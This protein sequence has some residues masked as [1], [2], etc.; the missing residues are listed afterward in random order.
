M[1]GKER[2][3]A[4][5]NH[6]ETA[7][8]PIDFGATPVSGIHV[9][10][11]EKLRAH[12][13]LP[14][15][16]IKLIEPYQMLGEIEPDLMEIIGI[17]AIGLS[18]L[19]NMFGM[20][21]Q[22]WKEFKTHWGQTVLVPESF[23]VSYD[24]EGAT[25]VFP[26]G[27]TSAEPS[28][29]MPKD[30]FFFDA[31]V[32]QK[33]I[34]EE[35]LKVED[36]LE[37]FG[38]LS[39]DDLLYWKQQ[40]ASVKDSDKAVVANFGGTGLGDI[41][42]VPAMNLRDP[43]GIR[44]VAEWYMSTVMRMDYVHEI[45][46]KQTDIALKNLARLKPIAGDTVDAVFICGTDFG[47]QDS[48]FCSPETYDE[49]YM[50]YYKK[51]NDW[52]HK[53]TNWKTFKHCCGAIESF[54]EQFIASGFDIMNPVQINATGMDPVLLKDKYGDRIT[55]WG[56]GVDTQK[57]LPYGTP[58]EVK[59]QVKTQCEILG[60]KGGFVFNAVHNIQ[61]NTP[62]ENVVAMIDTLNEINRK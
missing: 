50:P 40:I 6:T 32:R 26:A 39:D 46:E 54:M 27:D 3:K 35:Q 48:T 22:G 34:D 30:S 23:H 1:T 25:Y 44:D 19:C 29:K 56:G 12:F 45:F 4:A 37:E 5:L 21:Q 60:R 41:A 61:A 9:R 33:P 43:K 20:P 8:V 58:D 2:I 57:V 11:V 14:Q 10:I 16:P 24:N 55:F 53:N 59:K 15:K 31:I 18:P 28:A 42:L 36:N 38:I 51:I 62:I 13:A 49:L 17:D 47:T 52:I 7:S